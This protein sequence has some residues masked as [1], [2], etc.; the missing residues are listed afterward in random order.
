MQN[1]AGVFKIF[2]KFEIVIILGNQVHS[3]MVT[4]ELGCVF[5]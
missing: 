2:K 5:G 3:K 4:L 1:A